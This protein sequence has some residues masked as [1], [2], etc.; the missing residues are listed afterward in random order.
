MKSRFLTLPVTAERQL[1]LILGE[2]TSRE[3]GRTVQRSAIVAI[4]EQPDLRM[5]QRIAHH[6]DLQH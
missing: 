5:K 1:L 4:L 6:C 3:I 2:R